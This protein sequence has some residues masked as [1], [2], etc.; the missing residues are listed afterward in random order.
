LQ[1]LSKSDYESFKDL[2]REDK[3]GLLQKLRAVDY[4]RFLRLEADEEAAE[5]A[6]VATQK[7]LKKL[8]GNDG[9]KKK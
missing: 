5:K 1:Q 9:S 4:H 6:V 8:E 7:K 3:E 2:S